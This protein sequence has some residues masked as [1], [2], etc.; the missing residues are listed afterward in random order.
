MILIVFI[1]ETQLKINN[2]SKLV[3]GRDSIASLLRQKMLKLY[4]QVL[5]NL[6]GSCV[7]HNE[8]KCVTLYIMFTVI[9]TENVIMENIIFQIS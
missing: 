9:Q 5:N 8:A 6:F 4:F 2:F 1:I 3:F 7:T